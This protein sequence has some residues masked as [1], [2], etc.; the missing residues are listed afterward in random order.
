MARDVA[1]LAVPVWC[2]G[3]GARD[4]LWCEECAAQW[5]E[6]PLRSESSARRLHIGSRLPLPVWAIAEL[7]GPA[8]G[9]VG[10]WKDGDRRDLDSFFADAMTRAALAI[11]PDLASAGDSWAVVPIPSRKRSVARRG[12]DL[13]RLLAHGAAEGLR[14]AGLHTTVMA[15]LDAPRAEQRGANVRARWLQASRLSVKKSAQTAAL[16]ALMVD[17]VMTTGASLASAA[18]ALEVT[19]LTPCAALCLAAAPGGGAKSGP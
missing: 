15:V 4:V 16:P 18:R 7:E 10:A 6:E 2:P 1:R 9:M 5:W 11:A 13:P 3:C 8:H 19:F 17:D 12:A 14:R